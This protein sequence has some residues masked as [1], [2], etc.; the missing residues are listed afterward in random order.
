MGHSTKNRKLRYCMSHLHFRIVIV[1][2]FLIVMAAN[3]NAQTK[4]ATPVRIDIQN[5]YQVIENFGASDAWSCQF[6]GSWPDSAKNAIASWLFSLDTLPDGNPAGIGLSLWRFNIGA[7]S[8]GQGAA[9]GIRDEWRRA[10]AFIGQGNDPGA[11]RLQSQLWFLK[12]AQQRGVKQFLGFF[13]SP[14]V[15]LT[16]NKKA[17]ADSGRCNI[18][19]AQYSAFAAYAVDVL[20]QLKQSTGIAPVYLSPVNEPQ[21]NWSNGGQEGCPY[22]NNE[23]SNLIKA[24]NTALQQNRLATKLLVP[25]AGHH[26]YL[27]SDD[28]KPGRGN[29]VMDFFSTA[30]ANYIGNLPNVER[31][32]ASHSYFSTTPF[33]KAIALRKRMAEKV[34]G[35]SGLRY[36]Q[37]E[38]C[39]LGDNDGEIEGNKRDT[40]MDAALH[41]AGVIY[42]DLVAGNATAWQWWLAIS[43]Y[44][45]KDGLIYI[46][47][48]KSGGNYRDSKKLWALGNY[49]RFVRPG[50]KRVY[51]ATPDT[52]NLLVSAYKDEQHKK[53]VLVVVNCAMQGTKLALSLGDKP[54]P[55]HRTWNTYTTSAAANLEKHILPAGT[56]DLEPQC[57]VTIETTYD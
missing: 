37:S 44:D 50:M 17:Y 53:L 47:K 21:W 48:N 19:P 7:G 22:T 11:Q 10:E 24:F 15:Q 51:A 43:P 39:I 5:S 36:W 8:A 26:R 46:D 18:S 13:N 23:I 56:I 9:S 4:E 28:D 16:I 30:S 29:Q 1:A 52:G 35:V 27:L 12:A 55:A 33:P 25:E 32:V 38:Y 2:A 14:P 42:A 3:G 41:V 45:Y 31:V 34:A 57:I 49:S 54:F 20:K 6:A 40:G